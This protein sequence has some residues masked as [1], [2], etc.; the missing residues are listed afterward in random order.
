MGNVEVWFVVPLSILAQFKCKVTDLEWSDM[1]ETVF[2]GRTHS[3]ILQVI[4]C[5]SRRMTGKVVF[6]CS[7]L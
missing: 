4:G 2:Q 5:S 1:V 3:K 6:S 7:T